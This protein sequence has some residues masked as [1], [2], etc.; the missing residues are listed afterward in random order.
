MTSRPSISN[1]ADKGDINSQVLKENKEPSDESNKIKNESEKENKEINKEKKKDEKN[2]EN[3]KIDKRNSQGKNN[4][5]QKPED[6][7]PEITKV[8]QNSKDVPISKNNVS[9]EHLNKKKRDS[10]TNNSI[11]SSNSN[12]SLANNNPNIKTLNPSVI[13]N[14]KP[15]INMPQLNPNLFKNTTNSNA[16]TQPKVN[17]IKSEA[18]E[19]KFSDPVKVEKNE[20]KNDEKKNFTEKR[21]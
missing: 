17:E 7:K 9:F 5:S 10:N 4:S 3:K 8:D 21:N 2:L 12:S 13:P 16:S 6:V 1:N 11:I 18:P 20:I 15:K 19:K 14:E